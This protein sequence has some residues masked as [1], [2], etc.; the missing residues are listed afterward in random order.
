LHDPAKYAFN[1]HGLVDLNIVRETVPL[2]VTADHLTTLC[3]L[4]ALFSWILQIRE[5]GFCHRKPPCL[6]KRRFLTRDF[7]V[8]KLLA[9]LNLDLRRDP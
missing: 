1:L 6:Q 8:E 4:K 5:N 9:N 7:E 3:T 2:T